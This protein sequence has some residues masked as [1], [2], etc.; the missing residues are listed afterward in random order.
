MSA[1]SAS[2]ENGAFTVRLPASPYPGLRPFEKE[3]WPIF[4]GRERMAD[5]AV[6]R[7]LG[8]R[9]LV[10]HG[11]SGCGKSSLIRA[12]VLPRL[13]QENARGGVRWRT[14][15]AVPGEAPL[16]NLAEA[17]ARLDA[18]EPGDDRVRAFRRALNFGRR[19]PAALAELLHAG[20]SGG[21]HVCILV[22]QFEELFDHARRFGPDE[23]RLLTDLLIALYQ[24]RT[25]GLYAAVTMR[26]EF[27]G[28]CGRYAGFAELVN[29]TQ[30]LLPRME[31]DDLVRAIC[32]P[33]TLYNGSVDRGLATRLIAETGTNQDQLPL[34]QHGLMLMHQR[35]TERETGKGSGEGAWRLGLEDYPAEGGLAGLLSGHADALMQR[36]Q[37]LFPPANESDR[38]IEEIFKALTEI[39]AEGQAVRRPRTLRELMDVVGSDEARVRGIIDLYRADRVSLLRPYGSERLAEDARI[40]IGHEALIRCWRR[41]GGDLKDGWLYREFRSGM[42]W[43]ALLVQAESFATDPSNVLGPSATDERMAWMRQRNPVW[44]ERYGGN[45]DAVKTLLDASKLARDR[46]RKEEENARK[47]GLWFRVIVPFFA[48]LMLA[49]G[50]AV[51]QWMKAQDESETALI[52]REKA[53]E[54]RKKALADLALAK[55]QL[56]LTDSARDRSEKQEREA[57]EAAKVIHQVATQLSALE[58]RRPND[59]D[60]LAHARQQLEGQVKVLASGAPDAVQGGTT[61]PEI[62]GVR[63]Y[64]QIADEGQRSAARALRKDL[65][66]IKLES[67]PVMVPGIELVKNGP[68]RSVLRCFKSVECSGE[69]SRLLEAIN[70]LISKKL[71]LQDLSDRY[72]ETTQLRPLHFELWFASGDI[73][74]R[75]APDGGRPSTSA[76]IGAV[77]YEIV[78]CSASAAAARGAA[79]RVAS[80]LSEM[81]APPALR[82]ASAAQAQESQY[83]DGFFQVKHAAAP[84]AGY[85]AAMALLA[86]PGFKSVGPWRALAVRE[87]SRELVTIAVCPPGK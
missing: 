18:D 51:M 77:K 5:A 9:V 63:V 42:V 84:S 48:L 47:K 61:P 21:L 80:V 31:H 1:V 45:W 12:A 4:F 7:L 13:E 78:T 50:V 67:G 36:A 28:A 81:G 43:R 23:A 17:L 11:D 15:V 40:D 58:Q 46:A 20:D 73:G 65:A 55:Q 70:K 85:T 14:C 41:L 22:D 82:R 26:S 10:L 66:Q 29:E 68:P 79:D 34:I 76:A 2:A 6:A 8:Q 25:S 44:A 38:V 59:A 3:E 64:I 35:L 49:L 75:S 16:W 52:A 53:D 62:P 60:T 19:A 83:S 87:Q 86:Q 39:N 54:E 74:V 56:G 30:Y 32:E 24:E 69:G 72:G 27:I 37:K 57:H 71:E 33:A